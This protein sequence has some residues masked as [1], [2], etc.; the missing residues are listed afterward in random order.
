MAGDVVDIFSDA[1]KKFQEFAVLPVTG[2]LD[3]KTRKKMA[4][5]RCG[6]LDNVEMLSTSGGKSHCVGL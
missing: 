5:P 3:V 4:E 1:I 6:M 2:V